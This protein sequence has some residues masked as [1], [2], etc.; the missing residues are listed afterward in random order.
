MPNPSIAN[1]LRV[2]QSSNCGRDG[3]RLMTQRGPPGFSRLA[4]MKIFT[5]S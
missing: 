3:I 1:G 2:L 4:G 5:A